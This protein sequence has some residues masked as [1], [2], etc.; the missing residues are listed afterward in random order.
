MLQVFESGETGLSGVRIRLFVTA[1]VYF[2][3][4]MMVNKAKYNIFVFAGTETIRLLIDR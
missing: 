2:G 1:R 4:L 3:F